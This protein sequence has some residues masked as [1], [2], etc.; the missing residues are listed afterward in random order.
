MHQ[1]VLMAG[2][3]GQGIMLMGQMLAYAGMKEDKYVSWMPSY[4]PEQRGG[5]ANCGVVLSDE[6][7]GSP[8]VTEPT[9]C[10]VMNR[11]SLM[12]F[13]DAVQKDGYLFINSSLV[14]DSVQRDDIEVF[15]ISVTDEADAMGN[16]RVAN[17]IMLG[18]LSTVT[19]VVPFER[20]KAVLSEVL[21]PA[22]H[23]LIPINEQALE[24]GRELVQD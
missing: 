23:S 2:F 7:V 10:V 21:P 18:A 17:M 1:E 5:T 9:L 14:D 13:R 22:R 12:K 19:G 3:G 11:P 20:L 15:S 8:V 6:P 4:G 24:L 16:T